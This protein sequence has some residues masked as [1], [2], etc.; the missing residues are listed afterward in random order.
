MSKATESKI[1]CP[2]CHS[3]IL[4]TNLAAHK[5]T[6]RHQNAVNPVSK[7]Q[8]IKKKRVTVREPSYSEEESEEDEQDEQDELEDMPFEDEVMNG[9]E[10]L[11]TKLD[12]ILTETLKSN[13]RYGELLKELN[14]LA[15]Q[16]KEYSQTSSNLLEN[17]R[18]QVIQEIKACQGGQVQ[19][20]S[21]TG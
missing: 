11:N 16:V 12:H 4:K 14:E 8:S 15:R 18:I 9:L 5:K 13:V 19:F 17:I 1:E 2:D 7:D 6:K 10:H 20:N 3:M 21:K